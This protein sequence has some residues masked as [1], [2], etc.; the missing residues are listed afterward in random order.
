M[1]I[2][3]KLSASSQPGGHSDNSPFAKCLRLTLQR[4]AVVSMLADQL[5]DLLGREPDLFREILDLVILIRRHSVAITKIPLVLSSAI[6]A[7]LACHCEQWQQR[8]VP[9]SKR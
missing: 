8:N 4:F 9:I 3:I 2:L 5:A 1:A 6:A 7:L